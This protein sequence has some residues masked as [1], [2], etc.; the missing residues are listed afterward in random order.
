MLP[1]IV[2]DLS[3]TMSFDKN[4]ASHMQYAQFNKKGYIHSGIIILFQ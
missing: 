1:H 2:S 4:D 3:Q